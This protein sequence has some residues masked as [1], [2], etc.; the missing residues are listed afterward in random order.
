VVVKKEVEGMVE[1]EEK[2][3]PHYPL[4]VPWKTGSKFSWWK[5]QMPTKVDGKDGTKQQG[6]RNEIGFR[7]TSVHSSDCDVV[8]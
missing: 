7:S 1:E 6:T 2:H 5:W 3:L 4:G 8:L